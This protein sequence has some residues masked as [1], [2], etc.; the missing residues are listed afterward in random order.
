MAQEQDLQLLPSSSDGAGTPAPTTPPTAQSPADSL[1]NSDTSDPVSGGASVFDQMMAKKSPFMSSKFVQ[2]LAKGTNEAAKSSPAVAAAPGG[3][4]RTVLA[5]AMHALG[6]GMDSLGDAAAAGEAAPG[7]G[8]ALT[9]IARTLQARGQR[10][11]QERSDAREVDKNKVLMAEANIRMVHEQQLIHKM[12]EDEINESINTGTQAV[13]KLKGGA[14]P[15]P[16]IA[17]GLT[18]DELKQYL[19]DN[20]ID[21]TKET[22]FPTGRKV[23][24]T[25]KDGSPD[26]RTT[27]TAMGVPPE[28]KLDPENSEDK[29]MLDDMNK[30]APPSQGKWGTTGAQT[31][32]GQQFNWV[33]Q[34]V[35]DN[36]A[37]TMARDKTLIDQEL[38]NKDTVRKR[39]AVT[40]GGLD[41][42]KA[43]SEVPNHDPIAARN[44][45]LSNPQMAAKY[46]NLDSDLRYQYGEKNYDKML[47]DYQKKVD[48]GMDQIL[49]LRK[50]LDKSHG[51][52]AASLAQTFQSKIDDPST[53][54]QLKQQYA[55]MRDQANAQAKASTDYSANK[56]EREADA[57][58]RASQGDLS[59]LYDA[60]LNYDM[61]PDKLFSR[62][63][64]M[65][66]KQ[67]FLAELH[68]RDPNWSESEYKAR[69]N[70]VNDFRPEG[71]GGQA[72]QSL[73]TFAGH[74]GDAN[75][76]ITSLDNTRSPLFNTPINKMKEEILGQPQMLAY[77]TAISAAADEYIN[78]LLNQKA[79]HASD[80]ELSAKLTSTDTSPAMAQSMMRQMANTIAIRARALNKGYRDQ[81]GKD[82]PNYLDPDTEQTLRTFGIDPKSITAKGQSGLIKPTNSKDTKNTNDQSWGSQFGAV[83]RGQ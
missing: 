80:D 74:V 83:P 2:D 68:R 51:E 49:D 53:P 24:G 36:K 44:A 62:F 32:T 81:I 40:F 19:K 66:Q 55:R 21:P 37:K 72:K 82:I 46:P 3:W 16:V 26:Y 20:K 56:K 18:T 12:G 27:Y 13:S 30:Y 57:E 34:E 38:E 23:V 79:K 11:R 77:K 58:Q 78:F 67:E 52:E 35:A 42:T 28:V 59:Q 8:G 10:Q 61:D 48:T 65:K 41:W 73:N 1:S 29:K 50:T 4:A 7:G 22:P 45:M 69:Y 63:K 71:K 70:T 9:G 31:M 33:M 64:G 54:P 6:G 17:D 25:K 15:V 39:E 76:L 75:S 14:S 47:D 43:L 5:G 60:A